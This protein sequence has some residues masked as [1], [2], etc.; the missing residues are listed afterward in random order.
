MTGSP[1]RTLAAPVAL[2]LSAAACATAP[3]P[4][5]VLAAAA[6]DARTA[7]TTARTSAAAAA[8]AARRAA[9]QPQFTPMGVSAAPAMV[10][11]PTPPRPTESYSPSAPN[12]LW[13]TGARSFFNDQRAAHVGDILTVKISIDDSA[14]LSNESSR[15]RKGQSTV[16]VNNFG[17]LETIPGRVLPGGFDPTTLIDA[18]GDSTSSG[19]GSVARQ[20]KVELTVAAMVTDILP[21]GNFLVSGRQEVRVNAEMREL[22]VA[23]IIRPQDIAADN[24]IR[25]TEMAEARISYGGRGQISAVQRPRLGQ[26]IADAISPW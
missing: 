12:A 26:R 2:A 10:D 24:T 7:A 4:G 21:N 19:K 6:Q 9:G 16:G 15:S 1:L 5:A 17:G 14:D 20:E 13:R 23:G 25:H 8:E 3:P 11:L 22:T 18:S